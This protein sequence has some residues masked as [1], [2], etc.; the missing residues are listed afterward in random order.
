MRDIR[1]EPANKILLTD[2]AYSVAV[3]SSYSRNS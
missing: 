1:L 2:R 3:R